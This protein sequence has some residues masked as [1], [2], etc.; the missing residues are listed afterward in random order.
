MGD[1]YHNLG[2]H[3]PS[4]V[5]YELAL[6]K[7]E[8]LSLSRFVRVARI[9]IRRGSY[10]DGFSYLEK[11]DRAF[12]NSYSNEER[13]DV[14]LL[15]AEVLKAVGKKEMSEKILREIVETNPLEGKALIML[16]QYAW[17]NKEHIQAT[18]YFER[19]AKT[20]ES[21]VQALIEHARMR[22]STRDYEQAVLLLQEVQILDPQPRVDRYLKS[23][24]NLLLSSRFKP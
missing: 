15:Q 6:G 2:L 14:Q 11:I 10:Q 4:L 19:A 1:L 13:K 12:G 9:L 24:Q 5:N 8:K 3:N 21:K 16:G 17:E 20:K 18:L 23:I 7:K 22:V